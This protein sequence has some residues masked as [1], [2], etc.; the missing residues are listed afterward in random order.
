[1]LV[2]FVLAC[3]IE[4]HG[5]PNLAPRQ[6]M[7]GGKGDQSKAL[8]MAQEKISKLKAHSRA[9][10]GLVAT[11][12]SITANP[13]ASSYF[14]CTCQPVTFTVTVTSSSGVPSGTVTLTNVWQG[15]TYPM[16][17][18]NLNSQGTATL[19]WVL[20]AGNNQIHATFSG[21]NWGSSTATPYPYGA[22]LAAYYHEIETWNASG[23]IYQK[24][25]EIPG[26]L[27]GIHEPT[28]SWVPGH[29]DRTAFPFADCWYNWDQEYQNGPYY[30]VYRRW[31]PNAPCP[32]TGCCCG[33]NNVNYGDCGSYF[34]PVGSNSSC[35]SLFPPPLSQYAQTWIATCQM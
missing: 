16:G 35:A 28:L 23:N 21:R 6:W 32:E 18:V 17:K 1:V 5:F 24:C 22:N 7:N 26:E 10:N 34:V 8:V 14:Y 19:Q 11:K 2:A 12:I 29:C 33:G 13:S 30:Y 3:A 15:T 31:A 27:Y 4:R 9:K 20:G 25:Y